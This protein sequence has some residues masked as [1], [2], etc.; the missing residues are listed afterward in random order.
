MENEIEILLE[1]YFDSTGDMRKY[2]A[3]SIY[4]LFLERERE[5]I[6]KSTFHKDF[7]GNRLF[8]INSELEKLSKQ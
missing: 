6:V 2:A 1:R 5:T 4:K 3:K 7:A 8:E